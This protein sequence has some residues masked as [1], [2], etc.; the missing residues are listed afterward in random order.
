[1]IAGRGFMARVYARG[2]DAAIAQKAY[3]AP[4]GALA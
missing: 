4:A 3:R 2:T 1:M